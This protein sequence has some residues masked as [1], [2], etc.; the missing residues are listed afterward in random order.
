MDVSDDVKKKNYF[1]HNTLFVSY[2]CWQGF[3]FSR[4]YRDE[5]KNIFHNIWKVFQMAKIKYSNSNF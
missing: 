5:I 3:F 1:S 4:K 2:I